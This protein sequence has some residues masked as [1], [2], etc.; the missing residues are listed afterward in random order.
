MGTHPIFESDFDCQSQS[1]TRSSCPSLA[2]KQSSL[3]ARSTISIVMPSSWASLRTNKKDDLRTQRMT[4]LVVSVIYNLPHFIPDLLLFIYR[5][6]HMIV[7]VPI[8]MFHLNLV[9]D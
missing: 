2:V 6:T 7:T 1:A 3:T 8:W 4:R 9:T 5:L